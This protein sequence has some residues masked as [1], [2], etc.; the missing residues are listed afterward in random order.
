[1][2]NLRNFGFLLRDVSRLYV[3]RFEERAKVLG[4]TLSQCKVLVY[5]ARHEGI[6]QARLSDLTEL[7]PMNLVRILD[8]MEAQG[9]L[10]RRADPSDRRARCLFLKPKAKPVED[11]IWSV[12]D[13][14]RGEAFA[15][16]PRRQAELLLDLF[17]KIR[18]NIVSLEPLPAAAP[19]P[20]QGTDQIRSRTA[21][22]RPRRTRSAA[23]S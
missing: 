9:W 12:S 6:S 16:I 17:E 14:T 2:E 21:S 15:G 13:A 23:R 22:P 4:L 3:Q 1:M 5:L 8:Q 7:E 11:S 10:E 20:P 19:V 18:S